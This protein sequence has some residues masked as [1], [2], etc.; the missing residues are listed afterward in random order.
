MLVVRAT[1]CSVALNSIGN[2]P[3]WNTLFL[4]WMRGLVAMG[5][6]IAGVIHQKQKRGDSTYSLLN[7]AGLSKD[8]AAGDIK[9]ELARHWITK[10]KIDI[11]GCVELGMCWDLVKYSQ[12]LP[13]KTQTWWE[14]AQWSLGYNHLD[15]HSV[16]FSQEEPVLQYL[17]D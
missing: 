4:P 9:L 2:H 7:I 16:L 17:T 11:F 1:T 3:A 14:V 8:K 10:N 5:V 13:Q 12:R 15:T 6:M